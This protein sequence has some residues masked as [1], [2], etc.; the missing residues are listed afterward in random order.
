MLLVLAV[1]R[2]LS[3]HTPTRDITRTVESLLIT[4]SSTTSRRNSTLRTDTATSATA[5]TAGSGP[6]VDRS[7]ARDRPGEASIQTAIHAALCQCRS[8]V[9]PTYVICA[10]CTSDPYGH[11]CPASGPA[12]G[13]THCPSQTLTTSFGARPG[14]RGTPFALQRP[15]GIHSSLAGSD[16]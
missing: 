15:G 5:E 4:L 8:R 9:S 13:P 6:L 3:I 14:Y 12:V 10:D 2:Y 16:P 11:I 7:S 1:G